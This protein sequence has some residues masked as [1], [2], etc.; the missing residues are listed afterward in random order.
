[1]L[2][3]K[4]VIGNWK[5]N[6]LSLQEA[7]KLFNNIAKSISNIKK[8]EVVIC[9][10]FLYLEKLKKISR[11]IYLGAQDTFERDEGPFTGEIS[12]P[13]LYNIGV[14]YVILGH[15]ERRMMGENNSEINKEKEQEKRRNT[16]KSNV[17]CNRCGDGGCPQCEPWRFI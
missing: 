16:L 14:R 3:K 15:S 10:P 13:M 4:I 12:A 2:K 7:E 17:N 5:M 1:M 11:K 9:P 6:P 8:T